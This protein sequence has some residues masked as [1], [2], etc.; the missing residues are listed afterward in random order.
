[1]NTRKNVKHTASVVAR[2]NEERIRVLGSGA[3][4]KRKEQELVEEAKRYRLEL[5]IAENSSTKRRNSKTVELTGGWT[6]LLRWSQSN[7]LCLCE[8]GNTHKSPARS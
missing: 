4:S 1:M 5:D 3:R 6:D 8:C 2:V 7:S